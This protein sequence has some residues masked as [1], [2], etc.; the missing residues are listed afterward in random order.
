MQEVAEG[1]GAHASGLIKEMDMLLGVDKEIDC[2][3]NSSIYK[4][5]TRVMHRM[6][7][8][9]DGRTLTVLLKPGSLC[10]LKILPDPDISDS[11]EVYKCS[12][13]QNLFSELYDDNSPNLVENKF[14][15]KQLNAF[16][17][18]AG[19]INIKSIDTLDN[20]R[21]CHTGSGRSVTKVRDELKPNTNV[22]FK[23]RGAGISLP[24]YAVLISKICC[25]TQNLSEANEILSS[26]LLDSSAC[27]EWC[28]FILLQCNQASKTA[29]STIEKAQVTLHRQQMKFAIN[30]QQ[31]SVVKRKV[32]NVL[33][34]W[35]SGCMTARHDQNGSQI[36]FQRGELNSLNFRLPTGWTPA[37][38]HSF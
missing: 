35:R 31:R 25:L 2:N 8:L 16:D 5:F 19:A 30:F 33:N 26:L 3:L 34:A 22:S 10:S 12:L 36:P 9:R 7:I 28:T 17:S 21:V 14:W 13:G 38:S 18:T 15:S 6:K 32:L 27:R 1:K 20:V 37:Q 24:P 23:P 11:C 4:T 29:I